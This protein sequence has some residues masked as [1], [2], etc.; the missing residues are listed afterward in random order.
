MTRNE[1]A[2]AIWFKRRWVRDLMAEAAI[3]PDIGAQQWIILNAARDQ[4]V[5]IERLRGQGRKLRK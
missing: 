3:T 1:I 2:R 4:N 5:D